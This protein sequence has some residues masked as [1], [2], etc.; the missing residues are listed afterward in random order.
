[1]FVRLTPLQPPPPPSD[2]AP[3]E[4]EPY[5]LIATGGEPLSVAIGNLNGDGR[6]D[7]VMSTH[8][9]LLLFRQQTNGTLAA[10]AELVNDPQRRAGGCDR[11]SRR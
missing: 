5:N 4:F 6:K 10:P 1:L 2:S 9:K 8:D 3:L 11:R 7:V